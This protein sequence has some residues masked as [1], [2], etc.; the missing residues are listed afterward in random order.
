MFSDFHNWCDRRCERC[1]I[2][3][4]CPVSRSTDTFEEALGK[5]V[6][7]LEELC[8]EKGISLDDLPRPPP[9]KIDAQLLRNAATD[10]ALALH[11][12]GPDLGD[13]GMLLAGKVAR[14]AAYLDYE[15]G[16]DVW[17]ADAVPN[18]L[19]LE[20]LLADLD[21]EIA[22]RTRRA[23]PAMVEHLETSGRLL[24]TL[25]SPLFATIPALARRVLDALTAS[26]HAP[27]PFVRT[28]AP[29]TA[30]GERPS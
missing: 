7:M 12:V 26:G 13:A 14:I 15:D 23:P 18:L 25:L 2:E 9:P 22:P 21:A 10:H 19:L 16:D 11:D 3:P 17:Q 20:K 29:G 8:A 27:S 4:V 6:R 1:P 28:V 30:A 5:A 24:R